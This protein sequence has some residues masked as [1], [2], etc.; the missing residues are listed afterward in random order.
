MNKLKVCI[1]ITLVFILGALVGSVGTQIYIKHR[2]VQFAESGPS[3][4]TAFFMKRLS[5]KLKLNKDQQIEIK[6]ILY[7]SQERIRDFRQKHL[8]EIEK[9]MDHTFALMKEKLDDKQKQKLDEIHEDFKRHGGPG[10]PRHPHPR[11]HR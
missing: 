6:R 9:I 5:H 11:H 7:Q 8:P 3:E 2:I 1:G 4:K 10:F